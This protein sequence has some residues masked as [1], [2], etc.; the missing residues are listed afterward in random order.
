MNA[1]SVRYASTSSHQDVNAALDAALR[2][3]GVELLPMPQVATRIM[4]MAFDPKS[5]AAGLADLI[6][7]DPTL[8]GHLMRVANSAH[9]QPRSPLT[10]LQSAVAWLGLGEVQNLAV[11]LAVRG[12]VF[13]APGHDRD[14]EELWRESVATAAWARL[15]AKTVKQDAEVG[16]LCGLLHAVGRTAVI[17]ALSRIESANRMVF[18]TRTFSMLL[19]EYE[20][21][22]A[23]RV[24]G[25]WRL[26]PVV[27]ATVTGWRNFESVGEFQ[28]QAAM[29]NAARQL[30]T[31]SLH[32]DLLKVEYLASN[33][34]F[35]ALGINLD[36]L[37]Q[38]LTRSDTVR[39]FVA[40]L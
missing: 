21:D 27:A 8:A 4:S 2:E 9:Y 23:H 25:D 30:A 40:A 31:A 10:S 33:P 18:G 15:V 6:Q 19:D 12:Q 24:S 16:Y 35:T 11:T 5:D 1:V 14:V 29:I 20:Q 22:F 37:G 38:L 3:G 28:L 26:P 13:T 39:A 36:S 32:P 34:A 7:K 17:R